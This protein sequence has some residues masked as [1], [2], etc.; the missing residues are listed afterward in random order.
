MQIEQQWTGDVL[1]LSLRGELNTDE[2]REMLR[3]GVEELVGQ[4][5]RKMVLDLAR[6]RRVSSQGLGTLLRCRRVVRQS[7][8]ELKLAAVSRRVSVLIVVA[9]LL[10]VFDVHDTVSEAVRAFAL[11]GLALLTVTA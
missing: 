9:G 5:H 4:G 3:A 11:V 10:R 8:G 1:T 2:Q 7:G 6:L